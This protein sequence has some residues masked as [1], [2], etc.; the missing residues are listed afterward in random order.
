MAGIKAGDTVRLKSGGP[1]MTVTA[2]VDKQGTMFAYCTWFVDSKK[3]E[4]DFPLEV[5]DLVKPEGGFVT[6][7]VIR[8]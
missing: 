3:E 5:L 4:G 2:V 7:K 1:I 8:T 6:A